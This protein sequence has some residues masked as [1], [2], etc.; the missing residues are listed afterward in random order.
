[1]TNNQYIKAF[2]TIS[3]IFLFAFI[4]L[5]T[6]VPP[7]P[8]K[9]TDIS[10]NFSAD[11][12]VQHLNHIA[13]TAHPSGSVENEKVR[14]YLVKQLKLM[15]L[16]P[17]IEHSNHASLYPKMLTGGD[18][19]NVLVKLE[20]TGSDHAMMM[21][22][23]YDSVQQGPGA[24]DDGSGVAALLETI[25]VL[26]SAPPLKND[27]YFVFTDGE[28]QGLMGAKEFWTKSKH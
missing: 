10:K 21:S 22:A 14:N 3:F 6:I 15:G 23:H 8:D 11:R 12:A 5:Y 27:I 25:R 24:S 17:E 18:M 26:K 7:S 19:Y 28:E 4:S 2:T 13:K 1:M 20:G 16:Q 9:K